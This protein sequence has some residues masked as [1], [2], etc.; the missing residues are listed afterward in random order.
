MGRGSNFGG[1]GN[2]GRGESYLHVRWKLLLLTLFIVGSFSERLSLFCRNI[3]F[4][5]VQLYA[6]T[7]SI[8]GFVQGHLIDVDKG[9]A[10]AAFTCLN[11]MQ[12]CWHMV[13]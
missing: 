13:V 1:G 6:N 10:S 8:K 4:T 2:F 12:L 3:A 5:L 7:L 9:R 11:K